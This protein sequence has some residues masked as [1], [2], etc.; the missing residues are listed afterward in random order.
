MANDAHGRKCTQVTEDSHVMR[1][2]HVN[3]LGE[4]TN[5]ATINQNGDGCQSRDAASIAQNIDGRS[6]LNLEQPSHSTVNSD[7]KTT[8]PSEQPERCQGNPFHYSLDQRAPS[9]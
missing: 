6:Q 2:N 5:T 9:P 1:D 3:A 8:V 4:E 7:I